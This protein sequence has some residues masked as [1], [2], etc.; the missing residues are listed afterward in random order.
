VLQLRHLGTSFKPMSRIV[1]FGPIGPMI[2]ASLGAFIYVPGVAS[3]SG[4][5][6]V[7]ADTY[8]VAF[9]LFLVM[10]LVPEWLNFIVV[11]AGRTELRSSVGA[12]L[13]GGAAMAYLPKLVDL[14]HEN[15]AVCAVMGLIASSACWWLS[16]RN[17]AKGLIGQI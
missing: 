11:A 3:L 5:T 13:F 12:G 15:L 6:A 17:P 9:V 16:V 14:P 1:A 8:E 4:Q 7:G 2:I 10:G